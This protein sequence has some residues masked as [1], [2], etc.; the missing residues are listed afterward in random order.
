MKR[1]VVREVEPLKTTA[2]MYGACDYCCTY[3]FVYWFCC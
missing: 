3:D 1:F 2:A